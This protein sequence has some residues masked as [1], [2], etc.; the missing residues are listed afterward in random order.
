MATPCAGELPCSELRKEHRRSGYKLTLEP[1]LTLENYT[2][3]FSNSLR[4][5]SGH[6]VNPEAMK[7]PTELAA[8][9]TK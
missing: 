9:L 2:S 6:I 7:L 4:R 1:N 8:G 5:F 3:A